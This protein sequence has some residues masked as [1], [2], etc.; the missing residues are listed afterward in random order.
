MKRQLCALLIG[1]AL[2]MTAYADGYYPPYGHQPGYSYGAPAYGN[3][4]YPQAYPNYG[5][6][7]HRHFDRHGGRGWGGDGWEER[8]EHEWREHHGWGWR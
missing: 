8:R 7:E 3:Y 4:G 5:F 2:S 6:R 1:L